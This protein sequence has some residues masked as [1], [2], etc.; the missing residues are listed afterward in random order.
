MSDWN[1][2]SSP[3]SF[4]PISTLTTTTTRTLPLYVSDCFMRLTDCDFSKNLRVVLALPNHEEES[5]NIMELIQVYKQSKRVRV[6]ETLRTVK[7]T[8]IPDDVIGII[9]DYV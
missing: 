1:W 6:L 7:P 5:F 3:D 4:I 2:Y 9:N 8:F